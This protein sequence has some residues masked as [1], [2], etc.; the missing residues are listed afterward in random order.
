MGVTTEP[1]RGGAEDEA[2]A[3]ELGLE[4]PAPLFEVLGLCGASV[5]ELAVVLAAVTPAGWSFALTSGASRSDFPQLVQRITDARSS[6]P[7]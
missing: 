2:H 6:A 7:Q 4:G 1:A 5:V 3:P